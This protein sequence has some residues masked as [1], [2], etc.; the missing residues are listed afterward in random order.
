MPTNAAPTAGTSR[1]G[2]A[3][4]ILWLGITALALALVMGIVCWPLSAELSPRLPTGPASD[5][6][7][8]SLT[9]E[10]GAGWAAAGAP[11]GVLS[12]NRPPLPGTSRTTGY[13]VGE[14]S[15]N[16]ILTTTIAA[17][18]ELR[19]IKL[20]LL[21]PNTDRPP[22]EHLVDHKKLT[23]APP[24]PQPSQSASASSPAPQPGP[25]RPRQN[26]QPPARAGAPGPELVPW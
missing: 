21:D 18:P 1:V 12:V 10:T 25:R 26:R 3:G 4:D 15:S 17:P 23:Q 8:S 14:R 5:K 24:G 20:S 7:A 22:G 16:A 9:P 6:P 13:E 2:F 19:E 11:S